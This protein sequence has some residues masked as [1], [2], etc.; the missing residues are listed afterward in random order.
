MSQSH[1]DYSQRDQQLES[2]GEEI[3]QKT[4]ALHVRKRR[5]NLKRLIRCSMEYDADQP[6][7]SVIKSPCIDDRFDYAAASPKRRA[8]P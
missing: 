7:T 2:S 8:K 1:D 6:A 4:S 5:N 3:E